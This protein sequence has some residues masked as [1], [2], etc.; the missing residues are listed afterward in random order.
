MNGWLRMIILNSRIFCAELSVAA[1]PATKT[2][3][4][5][6]CSCSISLSL[7]HIFTHVR[8][9]VSFQEQYYNTF[10]FLRDTEF[11]PVRVFPY[12]GTSVCRPGLSSL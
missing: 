12:C 2:R 6:L 11:S 10:N 5:E 3:Q 1:V 8:A 7:R 9:G 4:K